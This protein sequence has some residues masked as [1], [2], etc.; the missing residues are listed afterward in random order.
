MPNISIGYTIHN[1][2]HLIPQILDGLK[3]SF[4]PLDEK[5]FLMD[6]CTD[7]SLTVTMNEANDRDMNVV[8]LN[9]T[10][11]GDMYEIEANNELLHYLMNETAGDVFV[12]FQ[13]DIVAHDPK[14]KEKIFNIIGQEKEH[15][16]MGGRSGYHLISTQYPEVPKDRVSNW[17]H[18]DGQ[19]GYRLKDGEYRVRTFLNRGPLVFTRELIK[20]VG[21]LDEDYYPQVC[22][23][24]D[25]CAR[26]AFKHG[27]KNI[28]FQCNVESKLEWGTTRRK[29]TNL[30][31]LTRG[32]HHKKNWNLFI[33]RWGKYFNENTTK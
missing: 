9:F 2:A 25:Y 4:G 29:D 28:V 13:D 30:W 23:D 26:C 19:Y 1:K 10:N 8:C 3:E 7:D 22:D 15:G 33:E 5:V 27:L 31:Q 18:K 6:N 32:K 20:K 21:Y 24:L 11:R 17:E 16:L 14:I 12:L